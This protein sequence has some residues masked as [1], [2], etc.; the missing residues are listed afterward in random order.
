[1]LKFRSASL[2]VAAAVAIPSMARAAD[3]SFLPLQTVK[4]A[5]PQYEPWTAEDSSGPGMCTFVGEDSKVRGV[6][7]G[8]PRLMLI[9]QYKGSATEAATFT[10]SLRK[11]F[12]EAYQIKPLPALGK[13]GFAYL[14][15]EPA[16]TMANWMGHA[17]KQVMTVLMIRASAISAVD[18][19]AMEGLT[20]AALAGGGK[21]G[22]AEQALSCPYFDAALLAKLLPG[23]GL[24]PQ[25][26]GEDSCMANTDDSSV[27]M[28]TRMPAKDATTRSQLL[29]NMPN[30]DCTRDPVPSLGASAVIAYNCTSGNPNATIHFAK[31]TGV[32]GVN[33]IPINKEPTKAQRDLLVTLGEAIVRNAA[34]K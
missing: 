11:E 15:K 12:A 2:A 33:L 21:S 19:E 29:A 5:F 22:A 31:D 23:A 34:A 30:T 9:Q 4:A 26:F 6:K 13:E 14:P 8:M 28:L 32:Y 1:M 18:R 25:K 16:A 3:C 7:T 20:A 27:V 10:T 24:K 17:D